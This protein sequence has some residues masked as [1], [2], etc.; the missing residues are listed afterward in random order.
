MIAAFLIWSMCVSL[1][2]GLDGETS[3]AGLFAA[4]EVANTGLHG[5]NRLASNSLLEGLV[6]ANRAV[7]PSIGHAEATLQKAGRQLHYVAAHADFSGKSLSSI[8]PDIDM[9]FLDSFACL[10]TLIQLVAST[11][12]SAI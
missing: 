4:G 11:S 7:E 10:Q 8:S 6:F 5:A 3:I 12:I 9:K 1:Q 2:T